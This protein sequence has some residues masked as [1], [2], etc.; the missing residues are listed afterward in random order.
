MHPARNVLVLYSLLRLLVP[1]VVLSF[2]KYQTNKQTNTHT[3]LKS[4]LQDLPNPKFKSE[5]VRVGLVVY[6]VHVAKS[7]GWSQT[8]IGSKARWK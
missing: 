5:I 1:C 7:F 3:R 4:S 8:E 6:L 2:N